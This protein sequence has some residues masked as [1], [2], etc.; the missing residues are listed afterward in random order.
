MLMYRKLLCA[1]VVICLLSACSTMDGG[2]VVANRLQAADYN[3]QL[4]LGYL[5]EKEVSRAKEKL[6]LAV[7]QA[8]RWPV[9]LDALAYFYEITG[10]IPEADKYYRKAVRF[11]RQSG[12]AQNNYGAFLCRQGRYQEAQWHLL[13]A[14][15]NPSYVNSAQAYENAGLC[16]L[17]ARS[18]NAEQYFKNAMMQDPQRTSSLYELAKINYNRGDY[19]QANDYLIRYAQIEKPDANV[20]LLQKQVAKHLPRGSK[21]S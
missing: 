8:P 5:Q 7:N 21:R 20:A 6:L 3:V 11:A 13:Q 4:G 14:A 17:A 18:A 9:A 16:A 1:M 2:Q 15:Q 12:Q 10:N 19:T